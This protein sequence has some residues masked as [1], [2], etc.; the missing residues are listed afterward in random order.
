MRRY[1]YRRNRKKRK[2]ERLKQ[3]NNRGYYSRTI[4]HLDWKLVDGEIVLVGKYLKYPKNTN[5][6]RFFKRYSNKKVRRQKNL[7][8]KGNGYRRQFD[9]A[10]VTEC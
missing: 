4:G 1:E 6:Q 10:W 9:Y 3:L 7:P 2:F 8:T 5:Q